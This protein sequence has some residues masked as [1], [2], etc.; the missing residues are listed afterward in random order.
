MNPLD[1]QQNLRW[2]LIK[3]E[4]HKARFAISGNNIN[5]QYE[6]RLKHLQDNE[7]LTPAEKEYAIGRLNFIKQKQNLLF[8]HGPKHPCDQCSHS[9]YTIMSCEHCVRDLLSEN[10]SNWSSGNEQIDTAIQ[11][12]QM[13]C[14]LP[15]RIIE[16]IDYKD[17]KDITYLAKGG[18]ATIYAATWESGPIDSF[19]PERKTF[20]RSQRQSVV[21]KIFRNSHNASARFLDEVRLIRNFI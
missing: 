8:L 5:E 13:K 11:D 2:E 7:K 14:P 15:K 6:G 3:K 21:L 12:A 19:D 18:Y 10:F 20:G 4:S 1:M 16:W 17:I 9:G